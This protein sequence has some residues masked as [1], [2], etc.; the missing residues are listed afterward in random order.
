[1]TKIAVTATGPDENSVVDP[2]FGRCRYFVI[3]TEDQPPE[4]LANSAAAGAQGAGL[5]AAR[6]LADRNVGVL[7]TGKVGPKA[8]PVLQ[9]AGIK[10]FQREGGTVKEAL[11]AFKRGELS[12][13]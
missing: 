6:L 8:L 2:R 9:K 3:V 5:A 13:Q 1:M 11:A 7:I 10:V 4:V 12:P